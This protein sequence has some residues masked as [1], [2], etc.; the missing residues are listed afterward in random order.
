MLLKEAKGRGLSQQRF[1]WTWFSIQ[2]FY[3]VFLPNFETD[4][5]TNVTNK[6]QWILT[7]KFI[8]SF[9]LMKIRKYLLH[10]MTV[11]SNDNN[12]LSENLVNS[13]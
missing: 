4:S 9:M 6:S 7:S 5:P 11:I 2:W 8:L 10:I 3:Q 12:V 1:W 13:H